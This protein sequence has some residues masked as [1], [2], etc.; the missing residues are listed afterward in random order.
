MSVTY[1]LAAYCAGLF[2]RSLSELT[3]WKQKPPLDFLESVMLLQPTLVSVSD[4][5]FKGSGPVQMCDSFNHS[6]SRF[7]RKEQG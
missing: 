7:R 1:L 6:V 3:V 5:S 2:I 4:I